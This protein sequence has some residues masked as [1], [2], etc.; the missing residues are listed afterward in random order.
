GAGSGVSQIGGAVGAGGTVARV[1]G[2]GLFLNVFKACPEAP[3][4]YR[5]STKSRR[6]ARAVSGIVP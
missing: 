6:E 3:E 4:D 5:G 2:D 1:P